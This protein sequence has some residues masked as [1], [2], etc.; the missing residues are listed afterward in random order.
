[1][2]F[3]DFTAASDEAIPNVRIS[4]VV[5]YLTYPSV[6]S[7]TITQVVVAAEAGHALVVNGG[8]F[9]FNPEPESCTD[10]VWNILYRKPQYLK[11][12]K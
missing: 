10:A 12:F 11:L 7:G 2:T 4:G 8:Q 1:V 9:T 5:D 6:L 3:A